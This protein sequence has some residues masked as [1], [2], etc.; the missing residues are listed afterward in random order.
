MCFRRLPGLACACLLALAPLSAQGLRTPSS[1]VALA[2]YRDAVRHYR[3]GDTVQAMQ[4]LLAHS[5]PWFAVAVEAMAGSADASVEDLEAAAL[6][7]TE[8]FAGAWVRD[9]E[10]PLH[11]SA[12]MRFIDLGR[13]R[14]ASGYR[15]PDGFRRTW[16]LLAAWYLQSAQQ[17]LALIEHLDTTIG[18]Y[19]DD[20]DVLLAQGTFYE[21]FGWSATL[22]RHP[23]AP[24]PRLLTSA[25]RNQSGLLLEAERVFRAALG[26]SP[27]LDEARLRLG[28]VLTE[29]GRPAEALSVLA[30]LASS[31]D[32]P[33]AYLAAMFSGAAHE[34]L[35]HFDQA[36]EAYRSAASRNPQC[37]TPLVALAAALRARGDEDA[38]YDLAL[39][40]AMA[41]SRCADPWWSYKSGQ[42]PWR[43]AAALGALRAA[44]R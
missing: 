26:Q 29:L 25:M 22:P 14:L 12:A 16:H 44:V 10:V 39:R 31:G 7:H 18:R 35:G 23:A 28:R 1:R 4:G 6:M 13:G 34:R 43:A 8:A 20:P 30:P 33:F 37:Q 2:E 5:R 38:S 19:P 40:T 11:L 15:L 42:W 24:A 32:A 36:I 21:I 17:Y 3:S 9:D 41:G 27:G